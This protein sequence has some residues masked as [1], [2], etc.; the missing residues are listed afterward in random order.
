MYLEV[1][2]TNEIPSISIATSHSLHSTLASSGCLAPPFSVSATKISLVSGMPFAF[3]V[4][5]CDPLIP[6]VALVELPPQKD[7]LLNSYNSQRL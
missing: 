1:K 5:V 7:D 2:R 3:C 4:F 6:D